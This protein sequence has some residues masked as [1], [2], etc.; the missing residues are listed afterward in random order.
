MLHLILQEN[1]KKIRMLIT[2]YNTDVHC[3]ISLVTSAKTSFLYDTENVML[4][5]LHR[6]SGRLICVVT[7]NE[8]MQNLSKPFITVG[9]SK[10]STEV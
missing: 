4:F 8:V 10:A 7:K 5:F 2:E 1:G 3:K 6:L 9:F